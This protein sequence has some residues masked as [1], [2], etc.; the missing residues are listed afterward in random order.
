MKKHII[1]VSALLAVGITGTAY[2][3]RVYPTPPKKYF[4]CKYVGQ[5]GVNETLQTGNNP[6]SVS[7]NAITPPV[8]VGAYF[9]DAQGRSYVVAQDTGQDE[10]SCPTP[11]NEP[12]VVVTPPVVTPPVTVQGSTPVTPVVTPPPVE[13]FPGK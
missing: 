10:P 5:P 3:T 9:N 6:I 11:Q 8:V 4:V 12:P 2:A 7:E 13:N 1:L